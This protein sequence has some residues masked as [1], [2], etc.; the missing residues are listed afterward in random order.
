MAVLLHEQKYTPSLVR[1]VG[2]T[3]REYERKSLNL[4]NLARLRDEG[5][6]DESDSRTRLSKDSEG[7]AAF[8]D[9]SITDN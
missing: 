6:E 3:S 1:E 8:S 9:E 7:F 2:S 4:V 5:R